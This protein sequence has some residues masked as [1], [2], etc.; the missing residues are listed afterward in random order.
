MFDALDDRIR[1]D[2]GAPTKKRILQLAMVLVISVV[3]FGGLYLIVQWA[4]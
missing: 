4:E 3:L 1:Q 2:E